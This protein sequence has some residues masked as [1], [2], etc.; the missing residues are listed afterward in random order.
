[1]LQTTFLTEQRAI[2]RANSATEREGI[3][4]WT[5]LKYGAGILAI[6]AGAATI[7]ASWGTLTPAGIAEIAGGIAL[8]SR[9]C[10]GSCMGY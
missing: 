4:G 10:C 9:R 2:I 1:M 3:D 5:I 8:L 7:A 6:I